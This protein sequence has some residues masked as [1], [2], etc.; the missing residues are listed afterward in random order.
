MAGDDLIIKRAIIKS[1]ITRFRK[2]LEN[3][4]NKE[5]YSEI[6]ERL[7]LFALLEP[8]YDHI[9]GRIEASIAAEDMG[10]IAKESEERDKFECDYYQLVAL[11]RD[12]TTDVTNTNGGRQASSTVTET[13]T[14]SNNVS[15][16]KQLPQISLPKFNSDL[17]KWINFRDSFDSLVNSQTTLS[18]IDKFNYLNNAL[19]GEA[20]RAIH[21]LSI[22]ET[23]YSHAWKKLRDRYENSE[24]LIAYH[25]RALFGLTP[26]TRGSYSDLRRLID[27]LH[28]HL[29]ALRSMGQ[30]VG[31]WDSVLIHLI[32]TKLDD[33]TRMSCKRRT[34]STAGKRTFDDFI[35]ILEGH[36]KYLQ[37][38][39]IEK[40]S[41]AKGQKEQISY[42]G[43]KRT[44]ERAVS[45]TT[46][47]SSCPECTERHPIYMCKRFRD[48]DIQ[49][50]IDR[51][52]EL[53]LCFNC[54]KSDHQSKACSSGA[55]KK[56]SR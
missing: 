10:A 25:T 5:K 9:Q 46:T 14:Y 49:G 50:R 24:E 21:S 45:L 11:A 27:D 31:T 6:R 17:S 52:T 34:L 36:C 29:I 8:E 38:E 12:L 37:T 51:V 19:E 2:F 18:N 1:K 40:Q 33:E 23:N 48:K 32:Y 54:L 13:T 16:L 56:C 20:A 53:R 43:G 15:I 28:N 3:P 22:S 42:K 35:T 26:M 41:I 47:M 4:E 55:C 44:N 7:E 30:A 39:Y